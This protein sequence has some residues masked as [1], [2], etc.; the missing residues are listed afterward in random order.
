VSAVPR[1]SASLVTSERSPVD[2]QGASARQLHLVD[3][4]PAGADLRQTLGRVVTEAVFIHS[5]NEDLRRLL[6]RTENAAAVA[7]DAFRAAASAYDEAARASREAALRHSELSAELQREERELSE[8][9]L[10]LLDAITLTEM[11]LE[12]QTRQQQQQAEAGEA[13][14]ELLSQEAAAGER[15][16][17]DLLQR[18]SSAEA[19]DSIA[20]G[21]ASE[22]RS[23]LDLHSQ[24]VAKSDENKRL[25]YLIA[26]AEE[27][28]RQQRAK[29]QQEIES[30]HLEFSVLQNE[31]EKLLEAL[32]ADEATLRERTEHLQHLRG[33]DDSLRA[34]YRQ[35]REQ[36][37]LEKHQTEESVSETQELKASINAFKASTQE[38][39][40]LLVEQALPAVLERCAAARAEHHARAALQQTQQ[41][42][43]EL[44]AGECA[45]QRQRATVLASSSRDL[46]G[47]LSA[48]QAA[49]EQEGLPE[50]HQLLHA[51]REDNEAMREELSILQ[52]K[53]SD[54]AFALEM[55]VASLKAKVEAAQIDAERRGI[56]WEQK[57]GYLRRVLSSTLAANEQM[58]DE[59]LA[60]DATRE[61]IRQLV[62]E[63]G[64]LRQHV[65]GAIPSLAEMGRWQ[66]S[67]D[68]A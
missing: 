36:L 42:I 17:T 26:E 66:T 1:T 28:D 38:L 52:R 2:L 18:E 44:N 19:D 9:R 54:E 35:V 7:D 25:K 34:A 45:N 10:A 47:L 4:G 15:M 64:A 67:W 57:V 41:R 6:G 53:E 33:E 29:H 43:A 24:L 37:A 31:R 55:L 62:E 58:R 63:N 49:A 20:A 61:Q 5:S 46:I 68:L 51:V 59:Q 50:P 14:V 12:E 11:A 65:H 60:V 3:G 40:F 32:R 13:K 23:A 22:Q 30:L 21:I 27:H 39:S 56:W 8:E 48:N 16:L